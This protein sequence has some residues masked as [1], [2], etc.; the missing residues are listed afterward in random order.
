MRPVLP[1]G[2]WAGRIGLIFSGTR[3]NYQLAAQLLQESQ[4]H[5]GKDC[6]A[7]SCDARKGQKVHHRKLNKINTMN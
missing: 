3:G 4:L 6:T 7:S 1:S 5:R 2:L